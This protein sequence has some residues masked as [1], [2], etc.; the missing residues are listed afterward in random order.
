MPLHLGVNNAISSLTRLKGVIVHVGAGGARDSMELV[1]Y[2]SYWSTP[3]PNI[4]PL[5]NL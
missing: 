1:I 5:T 2:I 4:I 3:Q